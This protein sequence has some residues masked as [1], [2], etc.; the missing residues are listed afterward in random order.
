MTAILSRFSLE[1]RIALVTGGSSG[2]GFAIAEA[3]HGAGA[4]IVL[5]ARRAEALQDAVDRLG[6][7][8]AA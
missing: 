5:C 6:S 8:A 1:G 3:L 7:R 2:I 4:S